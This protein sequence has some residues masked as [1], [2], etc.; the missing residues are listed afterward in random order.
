MALSD[1]VEAARLDRSRRAGAVRLRGSAS[2]GIIELKRPPGD[3]CDFRM[4]SAARGEPLGAGALRIPVAYSF[5]SERSFRDVKRRIK[6]LTGRS[7]I[8]L[9]LD[10]LVHALIRSF[11]VD[12]RPPPRRDQALLQLSRPLPLVAS[13]AVAAQEAPA[14]D[15]ETDQAKVLGAPLA[16]PDGTRLHWPGQVPVTRYRYRGHRIPAPWATPEPPRA[17]TRAEPGPP[18]AAP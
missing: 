11:G 5:P 8:G 4:A 6:E 9:S 1:S 16:R 12:K 17:I 14:A 10:G 7:T 2:V 18:G 13:D 15:L 3:T